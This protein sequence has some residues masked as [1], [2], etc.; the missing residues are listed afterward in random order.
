MTA[1]SFRRKTVSTARRWWRQ[2]TSMRTALVLLLILALAAVP[3]SLLP[4][5]NLNIEQVRGYFADNP[6]WHRY[7]TGCGP[8]TSTRHRGSPP[9]TCCCLRR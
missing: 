5:R 1:T 9:S 7:W 8:S 3:G 6:S 4:Q 2:L